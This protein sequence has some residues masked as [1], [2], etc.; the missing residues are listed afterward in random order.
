MVK[1]VFIIPLLGIAVAGIP[2]SAGLIYVQCEATMAK[3]TMAQVAAHT[4]PSKI[5]M[6]MIQIARRMSAGI[7]FHQVNCGW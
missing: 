7:D 6:A 2:S 3:R 4:T 5:G 1:N